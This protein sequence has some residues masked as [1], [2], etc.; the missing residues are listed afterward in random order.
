MIKWIK[1]KGD[2]SNKIE[3]KFGVPQCSMLEPLLFILMINDLLH[4]L[5]MQ[6][7]LSADDTT[8]LNLGINYFNDL[9]NLTQNTQS[10][11]SV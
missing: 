7:I 10:Q 2:R 4:F 3:L 11:A 8:F 5:N 9:H 6:T 1:N